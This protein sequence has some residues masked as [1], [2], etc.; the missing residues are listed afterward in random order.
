[1]AEAVGRRLK[2]L[3][4][5]GQ[6]LCVTHQAQIARFA[7]AHYLVQ[8]VVAGG[9]TQTSVDFLEPEDRV[10]EMARMIAGDQEAKTTIE[11]ARWMLETAGT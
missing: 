8:K 4:K 11:T 6:V 3:A 2:T 7:D 9:R 5:I 10:K 1:V